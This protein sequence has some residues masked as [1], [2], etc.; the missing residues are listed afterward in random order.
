MSDHSKSRSRSRSG[1]RRRS[2]SRSPAGDRE[3]DAPPASKSD[4]ASSFDLRE[5]NGYATIPFVIRLNI[6]KT[7]L[8]ESLFLN[9]KSWL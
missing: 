3:R 8:V 7:R 5:T 4:N 6:N 9:S 2:R 1:D